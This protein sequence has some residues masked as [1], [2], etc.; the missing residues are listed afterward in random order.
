M[1]VYLYIQN[2]YI[3][4]TQIYVNTDLFWMRLIAS[5]FCTALVIIVCK[6]FKK[7]IQLITSI[8]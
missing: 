2:N 1:C 5:N 7:C 4:Y 6:Q 8:Y 3:Q